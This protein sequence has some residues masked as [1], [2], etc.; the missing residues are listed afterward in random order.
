[1]KMIQN[2][3]MF[4]DAAPVVQAQLGK[5]AVSVLRPGEGN[6]LFAELLQ[7]KQAPQD[8]GAA[9]ADPQAGEAQQS[10]NP[11]QGVLLRLQNSYGKPASAAGDTQDSQPAVSNGTNLAAAEQGV[12]QKNSGN[13]LQSLQWQNARLAANNPQI[14]TPNPQP[15][16]TANLQTNVPQNGQTNTPQNVQPNDQANVQPNAQPNPQ[17]N[18]QLN[19][20]SNVQQNVEASMQVNALP[21]AKPNLQPILS[22]NLKA[23]NLQP[24]RQSL[25]QE[26]PQ[27]SQNQQNQL[28]VQEQA[29]EESAEQSVAAAPGTAQ[30]LD[31][32]NKFASL[33]R[34]TLAG[35]VPLAAVLSD[36][37]QVKG[38]IL[39]GAGE[40]S[41]KTLAATGGA[42]GSEP[43]TH[44]LSA[45]TSLAADTQNTAPITDV[46]QGL[47]AVSLA[48]AK[49]AG[50]VV[51]PTD[52]KMS[53][54]EQSGAAS[55][56]PV[57]R[58]TATPASAAIVTG[59]ADTAG[60][61]VLA[62][63]SGPTRKDFG[64]AIAAY[65][66]KT[67]VTAVPETVSNGVPTVAATNALFGK[68]MAPKEADATGAAPQEKF[69]TQPS[70]APKTSEVSAATGKIMGQGIS[71]A[72]AR[73]AQET[74]AAFVKP[75]PHVMSTQSLNEANVLQTKTA[76][77]AQE[78]VAELVSVNSSV[79]GTAAAAPQGTAPLA[80]DAR[81]L[82]ETKVSLTTA[83]PIFTG[84]AGEQI[85][86]SNKEPL[87]HVAALQEAAPLV[88][89]AQ[90]LSAGTNLQAKVSPVFPGRET[91]QIVVEKVVGTDA[92]VLQRTAPVANTPGL[93]ESQTSQAKASPVSFGPEAV[94][95]VAAAQGAGMPFV[96]TSEAAPQVA[97]AQ[98]LDDAQNLQA[99]T[100]PVASGHEAEQTVV[101]EKGTGSE[102]ALLQKAAQLAA[103]SQSPNDA[104]TP[105]AAGPVAPEQAS[106]PALVAKNGPVPNAAVPK[107]AAPLQAKTL[108]SD[109]VKNLQA[110]ASPVAPGREAEQAVVVEKGPGMDSA[111]QDQAV[112]AAPALTEGPQNA[113]PKNST[114]QPVASG[115]PE[116]EQQVLAASDVLAK[117][118]AVAGSNGASSPIVPAVTEAAEAA[119][120]PDRFAQVPTDTKGPRAAM[121]FHG[122]YA[123][124]RNVTEQADSKQNAPVEEVGTKT[125]TTAA[126]AKFVPFQGSAGQNA[127][128]DS[129]KKGHPEQ[130]AQAVASSSVQPQGAGLQIEP[131]A[132]E[133][134][135]PEAKPVNLKSALH[136]S[137][138]SQIKDGVVTQ[139]S[140][141][142]GQMSIRLNPGELGELKIQVRM[143]DNKL[144]VEVHADNKMV[145]D[146][147]MSNLDSLKDSLTSKNFTM[148]G[149]DVSTGGGFN[150]PLPEQKENPRQQAFLRSARAGAYPDQG[151]ETKVNY[152]TGEVNNLLDVRF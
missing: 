45:R 136:E 20:Q 70:E 99:K 117:A 88:E 69:I 12:A 34:A 33:R 30:G 23:V 124:V 101:T 139:D 58:A 107:D 93:N 41:K 87:L 77:V 127:F 62:E 98:S 17:A 68:G 71:P 55:D 134:A 137:I 31:R 50:P 28:N 21:N 129:D 54:A 142:N 147:L 96:A 6:G 57:G 115:A 140:K 74:A 73:P 116:R 81:E 61:A 130:K 118:P 1:M 2:S 97:K 27:V 13:P 60:P 67:E 35:A 133:A 66:L 91:D 59:M 114:V 75:A 3:M 85:V 26:Q 146:L 113:D 106:E 148:E 18:V 112:K 32:Q 79:P 152:L 122:T 36:T 145:K 80:V 43:E 144:H 89:D 25:L 151:E 29:P 49:D 56:M 38:A 119:S 125:A 150:S 64:P 14:E 16:A 90:G 83:S 52:S 5:G 53:N 37:L 86:V 47:A 65:N 76:P 135:L 7:G 51:T 102:S 19:A 10:T 138:L 123:A 11:R 82:N 121:G 126:T 111:A 149:F 132:T 72:A 46:L 84:R 8:N 78:R 22:A 110:K 143:D 120:R 44:T 9:E 105:Q 108:N 131:A 24:L 95:V 109:E 42:K 92:A 48:T 100:S 40:A 15:N 94:Q 4:Q 128:G 39:A 63:N 104:K 141:G 103:T